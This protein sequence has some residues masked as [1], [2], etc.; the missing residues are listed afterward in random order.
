[1]PVHGD[2]DD[3]K[4]R[5]LKPLPSKEP[6]EQIMVNRGTTFIPAPIG[7]HNAV[8]CDIVELGIIPDWDGKKRR[9]VR[10]MW[11]IDARMED[12]R[13]YVIGRK[14]TAT[15]NPKGSLRPD[16]ESWRGRKFTEEE[17]E[18]F[19]L[20]KLLGKPCQIQVIHEEKDGETFGRVRTVLPALPPPP[21]GPARLEVE[22]YI[23]MKDRK[24]ESQEPPHAD[25]EVPF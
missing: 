2:P 5:P 21:H 9:K 17:V 7:I 25:E 12:G 20:V 15:L 22:D 4:L 14:Y 24:D 8:C 1:M 23:R 19:N 10:L 18:G 11:Q 3:Q 16:L 13:R 6:D